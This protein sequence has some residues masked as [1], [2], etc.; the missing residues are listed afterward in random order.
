V[1][2][3]CNWPTADEHT[4]A[5]SCGWS[6]RTPAVKALATTLANAGLWAATGR[7]YGLCEITVQP[8][9][10]TSDPLYQTYPVHPGYADGGGLTYPVLDAG[11]WRNLGCGPACSCSARCE[12]EIPGPTTKAEVIAVR[13]GGAVVDPDAYQVHNRHLLVRIDGECW[14]SCIDYSSQSPPEF[15]VQYRRGDPI[16]ADV[17][18][19]AAMFA[20]ELAKGLTGGEC[21]LP[22]QIT[23][24]TRQGVEVQVADI[25]S[26]MDKGLTQIDAVDRVIAYRNPG[27]LVERPSVWSPDLPEARMVT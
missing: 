6:G 25:T 24:L 13:V 3:P 9:R 1:N 8:C 18:A 23:R 26:Y 2:A 20:C 7:R 11:Q 19:A 5:C 4:P 17:A 21:A 22:G 14:P 10:P 12:V 15:E 27:R 16:P